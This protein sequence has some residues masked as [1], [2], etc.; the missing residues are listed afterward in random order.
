[1]KKNIQNMFKQTRKKHFTLIELLVVIAIIAILAAML[2]PALQQ[3]R[4]RARTSS[5]INNQRQLVMEF[6]SYANDHDDIVMPAGVFESASSLVC[7][8][9][10]LYKEGRIKKWKESGIFLCPEYPSTVDFQIDLASSYH[11]GINRYLYNRFGNGSTEQPLKFGNIKGVPST[12]MW[13]IDSK[14]NQ[15]QTDNEL[16]HPQFRHNNSAVITYLGGN[17]STI[18]PNA[19][20]TYDK[21]PWQQP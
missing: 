14:R 4:A 18:Q 10:I 21:L 11:Y 8:A 5:C 15:V 17:I 19:F 20:T 16:L 3:A 7:W 2:L 6:M 13:M 12:I 1:M 9:H